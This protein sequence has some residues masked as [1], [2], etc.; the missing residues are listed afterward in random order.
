MES[1]EINDKEA[2][3]YHSRVVSELDTLY[4]S[5]AFVKHDDNML[6]FN[7]FSQSSG[8]RLFREIAYSIKDLNEK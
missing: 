4:L 3:V 8:V 6:V 2:A 7:F 5:Q 1:T